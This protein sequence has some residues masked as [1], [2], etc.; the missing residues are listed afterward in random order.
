MAEFHYQI[1][2]NYE[3]M[4]DYKHALEFLDL[5]IDLFNLRSENP[6]KTFLADKRTRFLEALHISP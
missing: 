6:Y 3:R 5:S 1:G 2:Y 4:N